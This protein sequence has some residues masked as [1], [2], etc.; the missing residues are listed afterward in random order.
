MAQLDPDPDVGRVGSG[1]MFGT[2]QDRVAFG[3]GNSVLSTPSQPGRLR[4]FDT[5]RHAAQASYTAKCASVGEQAVPLIGRM[6]C[7][8]AENAITRSISARSTT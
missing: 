2:G 5:G 8:Q 3:S 7:G 4:G 1:G 6:S